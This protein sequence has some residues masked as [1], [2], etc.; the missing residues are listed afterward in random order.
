MDVW[1]PGGPIVVLL[2][3]TLNQG[4]RTIEPPRLC[5][6]LS[7]YHKN[8]QPK[9]SE[10]E[11]CLRSQKLSLEPVG[12]G[13]PL[14]DEIGSL[15]QSAPCTVSARLR[16]RAPEPPTLSGDALASGFWLTRR[17]FRTGPCDYDPAQFAAR[18][19]GWPKS[20]S[21]MRA[22]GALRRKARVNSVT[23][24]NFRNFRKVL[25]PLAFGKLCAG[26]GS[27][28]GSY[29]YGSNEGLAA[30]S[31]QRTAKGNVVAERAEPSREGSASGRV[32]GIDATRIHYTRQI[33]AE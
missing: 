4:T 24:G 25:R 3:Q 19:S 2:E 1:T 26:L 16:Q 18:V 8:C 13:L 32:R 33:F 12:L 9:G 17:W 20:L 14:A 29:C 5:V 30:G 15:T 27:R 22:H 10:F 11:S 21:R 31:S 7:K 28:G 6:R 23:S